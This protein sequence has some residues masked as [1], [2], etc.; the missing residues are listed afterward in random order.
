MKGGMSYYSDAM[1]TLADRIRYIRAVAF[2]PAIEQTRLADLLGVQRG[3]VGNW[4]LGGNISRKNAVKLAALVPGCTLEWLL[5]GI[6]SPPKP[7]NAAPEP[8]TPAD[9][10]EAIFAATAG[11]LQAL[12]LTQDQVP[13]ILRRLRAISEVPLHDARDIADELRTR[14]SL[15]LLEIQRLLNPKDQEDV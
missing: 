14:R 3:A 15:A 6:G 13:G 11:A 12:G 10:A 5:S 8:I 9:R 2:S 4:E 7:K 1:E